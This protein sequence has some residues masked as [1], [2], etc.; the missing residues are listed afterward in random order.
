MRWWRRWA[1]GARYAGPYRDAVVRSALTLKLLTYALSGRVVAAPTTSLPEALGA[2]RNWDYRYCW[3]RD[4][5]LTMRA[6][7]RP[8]L[9]STRRAHSSTGCCTRR[10]SP[11]RSCRCCT[12]CTARTELAGAGAQPLAWLLRFAAGAHRQRR[13]QAA[14]ARRL[15]RGVLAAREFAN[16]T[17]TLRR[18]EARLLRRLRR[19]RV[20]ALAASPTTASGR[21]AGEPRQYTFSKVMCWVALDA[22]IEL[23]EHGL[24]KHPRGRSAQRA[25]HPRA[26]RDAGLQPRAGQL[27]RACSTA[28][29]VDASLLLIGCLGYADPAHARMRGTFA[30]VTSGSRGNGLLMRYEHGFDGLAAA[31]GAFGICSFW[32]IDYLARRG[33]PDEAHAGVRARARLRQ[34]P[35]PVRRG[36]R[37]RDPGRAS[38]TS[39]RRTPMWA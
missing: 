23:A 28:T 35:R 20:P 4:A 2:D 17:G 27:R 8:R 33:D 22:L 34:R 9:S 19:E 29:A 36:D 39:R 13:A 7:T 14:A 11:G 18:D 6:F 26:D 30:S 12:T 38:A 1:R 15:W 21:S 31:E 24:L 25:L 5:A 32:A 16:A 3:L 37:S 10:A